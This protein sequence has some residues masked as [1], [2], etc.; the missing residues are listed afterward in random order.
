MFCGGEEQLMTRRRVGRDPEARDAG[1]GVHVSCDVRLVAP[2]KH[3]LTCR[4]LE[5]DRA[6]PTGLV[7]DD[8]VADVDEH[9]AMAREPT[10]GRQDGSRAADRNG[11]DG[12]AR[13]GRS[14][15]RAAD[16]ITVLH[17]SGRSASV[18]R[19]DG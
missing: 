18:N 1:D 9:R 14:E 16:A 3:C 11:H 8:R 6:R 19:P 4:P 12:E 10:T 5:L 15:E 13:F 17:R 2:R 7:G